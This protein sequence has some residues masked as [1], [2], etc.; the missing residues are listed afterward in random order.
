MRRLSALA[1]AVGCALLATTPA[2]GQDAVKSAGL[3][4][5]QTAAIDAIGRRSIDEHGTPSVVIAVV[6][7]GSFVYQK[8]FG[9]RNVEDAVPADAQTRY[10]IGS[11]TKQFTAASILMLQDQGKL[12]IDDQLAKYL[13]E[14]PHAHEVTLRNL[15][16]H[17]GGYA[18]YTEIQTFDEIGA[19]PATPA[20]IV[21]SVVSHPLGFKPGTK[22][23]YSNTGYVLLQMVIER[24][25][26]MRYADFLDHNIFK[27]LGMTSTYVKDSDDT[28]R[29]VATEYSSFALGPWEH[30]LHIDYTWFGGAGSIVSN[31]A[32]LAKWNAA[33][34]G[35]KLLS[36]RSQTEMMT[37]VKIDNNFPDYGLAI[38]NSKLPNGHHMVF[39]GGNTTGAATQ[40]ARFP[41]DHLA[42]VVLANGGAYSYTSA[43]SAIYAILVPSAG[44]PKP[45]PKPKTS[46]TPIPGTS[47][48]TIA[49]AKT[50]L[51]SAIGGHVDL[52]Q[53]RPD[54][55]ARMDREHLAALR[56]LGAYGKRTYTL[57]NFDRRVPT[58]SYA[59]LVSAGK[60]Q[61]AYLY[62]RDDDGSVAGAAIVPRIVF[63]PVGPVRA[64]PLPS[65]GP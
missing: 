5:T 43:V 58:S 64:T 2:H 18:E 26:G 21:G 55:R 23:Q 38:E 14:I 4:P 3:T 13:P 40:D 57:L 7:N 25:S 35:G 42:I 61:V 54:F 1:I 10:P 12:R 15:L 63:P 6:K 49:A 59:F 22:R 16:M 46:P 65:P 17:T 11:N 45:S 9:L 47:A 32:D 50:W 56:A 36:K 31:A 52:A 33:L 34:D 41:D 24:I 28:Q 48:A 39:H 44:T 8:G 27:P 60:K 20:E 30:A 62:S 53:L 37:P 29:D 51:D 19:R